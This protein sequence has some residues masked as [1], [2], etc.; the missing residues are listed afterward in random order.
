[1]YALGTVRFRRLL[2]FHLY[3][4][5]RLLLQALRKG[6]FGLRCRVLSTKEWW[7][8]VPMRIEVRRDLSASVWAL[9]LTTVAV[10]VVEICG[11]VSP[12]RRSAL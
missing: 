11:E 2:S 4:R 7:Y 8:G 1:M 6:V 3:F 10:V 9:D 12:L 5:L